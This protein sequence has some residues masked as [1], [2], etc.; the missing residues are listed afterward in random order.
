MDAAQAPLAQPDAPMTVAAIAVVAACVVTAD[1]EALGHGTVCLALG[2][3]IALVTSVYFRCTTPSTWIAAG[4]PAGNLLMGA[5][6]WWAAQMVPPRMSRF[7]W[8]FTLV[9]ALSIFWEAGYLLYSSVLGEGDWAIVARSFLGE[10]PWRWRPATAALGLLLYVGGMR[11]TTASLRSL[12]G[13]E[14]LPNPPHIRVLLSAAWAAATFSACAAA[15]AYTPDRYG[16]V[17]QAF[18]EIGAASIPLLMLSGRLRSGPPRPRDASRQHAGWIVTA[19][20]AYSV[21]VATLGR[22]IYS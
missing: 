11:L 4:G 10:S 21:F 20:V 15:A 7:R 1:H 14:G 9:A 2:G 22:G 16:A 8:L 17:Q 18:L 5:A 3:H 12:G 6:A 13:E 19:A